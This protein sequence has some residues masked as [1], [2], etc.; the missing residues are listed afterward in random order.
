MGRI[1]ELYAALMSSGQMAPET[2]QAGYDVVS[3]SGER[4]SVKTTTQEGKAGHMSF[5][6]STIDQVDRVMVFFLNTDE[7]QID[8]LLDSP[9]AEAKN[10]MSGP[11]SK[12]KLLLSLGKLRG[13]ERR[14]SRPIE[15]QQVRAEATHEDVTIRELESGTILVLRNGEVEAVAKPVL[16]RI[17]SKLGVSVVN[18]NGNSHNTRQLGS[19]LI[20]QLREDVEN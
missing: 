5:S 11:D 2:N 8:T 7:M 4:I 13:A 17:A 1:G 3:S 19:L 15:E 18:S 12:G 16:R 20:R 6:S 9:M 14:P 10:L